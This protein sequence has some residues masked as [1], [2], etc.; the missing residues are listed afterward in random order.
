MSKA[1]RVSTAGELSESILCLSAHSQT[2][3]MELR[4]EGH[5]CCRINPES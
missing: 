4:M 1:Q 5:W 3:M 2:D